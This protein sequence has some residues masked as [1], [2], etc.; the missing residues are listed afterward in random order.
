MAA[1]TAGIAIAILGLHDCVR[2]SKIQSKLFAE[3]SSI[4]LLAT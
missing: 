4:G 2:F 3:Y 1:Q